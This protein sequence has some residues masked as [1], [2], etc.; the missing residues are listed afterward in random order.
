MKHKLILYLLLYSCMLYAQNFS[1][2]QMY[3]FQEDSLLS[4]M[5]IKNNVITFSY[6]NP[7]INKAP[8]IIDYKIIILDGIQFIQLSR[9]MPPEVANWYEFEE[10]PNIPTDDKILFLAGNNGNRTLMFAFTKGYTFDRTLTYTRF[11]NLGSTFY[12]CSSYLVEKNKEYP[13]ENLLL[14][15]PDTPWV[16]GV[17]GYGIGEGFSIGRDKHKY[18]LL[19]NGYISYDKPYLYKQNTRIKKLKVIGLK[20]GKE[21]I[22]DVLDT[23]HPQT[24]DISFLTENEDVRVTIEDVFPGTKYEDTCLHYMIVWDEEVIPYMNSVE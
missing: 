22:L 2:D 6:E 3:P 23:P 11:N 21:K 12:D 16:E 1:L 19:M 15:S 20:S 9:K 14:L 7:P 8:V 4:T 5:I 24:I 17:P 13:I 10:N 18:L